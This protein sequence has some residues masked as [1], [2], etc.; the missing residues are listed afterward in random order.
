MLPLKSSKS[1]SYFFSFL[2]LVIL[3]CFKI[4]FQLLHEGQGGVTRWM[5]GW[6]G[7][8]SK[9]VPNTPLRPNQQSVLNSVRASFIL[10]P[11][12]SGEMIV[13]HMHLQKSDFFFRFFLLY[14]PFILGLWKLRSREVISLRIISQ[15][16][17]YSV[18]Y[19]FINIIYL[20]I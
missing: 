5:T 20:F 12:R 16:I 4:I 3:S 11:N 10:A 17:N 15:F 8:G 13:C 1:S 9:S 2:V 14:S 18:I 7:G 19:L 6:L